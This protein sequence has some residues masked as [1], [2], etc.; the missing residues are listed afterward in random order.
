MKSQPVRGSVFSLTVAAG[1][2]TQNQTSPQQSPASAPI[3]KGPAAHDARFHGRVLVA[4]DVR[5]NQILMQRMLERMGLEVVLVE[6]GNEA[7]AKATHGSYDLILMD[8]QMPEKNG[9]EA[10]RELRD[11]GVT[12]PIVALT[13]HA[14]K[15]DRADC[16]AAGCDD[17]LAKPIERD[18]LIEILTQYLKTEEDN[19]MN[20]QI[21]DQDPSQP[22]NG[23]SSEV[24]TPIILW[25]RLLSRIGDEDLVRELMPVC[26]QDNKTRLAALT[27][28]VEAK[29]AANVKLYA[30]AIKGSSAN[31]GVDQLSEA[32]K[33]L[34]HMAAQGDLSQAEQCLREIRTQFDRFEA[35]VSCPDW[36][37]KAKQQ[38]AARQ[39]QQ[40]ACGQTA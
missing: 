35:F 14:M 8:V 3:S 13:A 40:P 2:C 6:D 34:E 36:I 18:K 25:D 24:E 26:I 22:A 12:T 4:E 23:E 33:R 31:L 17:Y 38:E 10:T 32:A 28:A 29:D 21:Q 19:S 7:V 20:S 39:S 5:T 27:E 30:H 37:E 11:L 1:V 9:H 15:E 16:L